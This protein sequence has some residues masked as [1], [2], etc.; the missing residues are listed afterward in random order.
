HSRYYVN[1]GDGTFTDASAAA[2]FLVVNEATSAP[3]GKSLALGVVDFDRDGALDVFVA[4]DTVRNFAFHNKG[5]GTFEEVGVEIGVAYDRMGAATGAMGVDSADLREDGRL[6]LGIGN[7]ANEM[8]SLYVAGADPMQFTDA[9][10]VEG[11]G[12]ASRT[13]LTFGLLFFDADLD[14]RL[15]LLQ[16]NGHLEEEINKVQ[17]SQRYRQPAQLFWNAG[18]T[19]RSC[20]IEVPPTETG[21]FATPIV[22]RGAA[23]ADI[24]GDGDLDLLLTQTGAAPLLLRNDDATGKH[25]LRFRLVGRTCNR[26]AIG[27]EI[28]VTSSGLTRRRRVMPTRGY[29]SQCELPV[30][31]GLGDATKVDRVVI[32]WPGGAEQVV[33]VDGLDRSITVVQD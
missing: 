6:A 13:A 4:N 15:D 3:A 5:D 1:N 32:H 17:S 7:F 18:P 26:D 27:A 9:S 23:C 21:D 11:V 19:E 14:G 29:L 25:W 30:T 33:D 12:A 28:E 8:T 2:G 24:D 16:C 10:I 20:F 22:G 31:F